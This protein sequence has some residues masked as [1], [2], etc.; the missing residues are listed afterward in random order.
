[1]KNLKKKIFGAFLSA[2]MLT[3]MLPFAVSADASQ[4]PAT[5]NLVWENDFNDE[6]TSTSATGV[7][8]WSTENTDID[9]R[10]E[11]CYYE[12]KENNT[13]DKY[14]YAYPYE[15]GPNK[16]TALG[17]RYSS[18]YFKASDLGEFPLDNIKID[19]SLKLDNLFD[20]SLTSYAP[21]SSNF[22]TVLKFDA[23]GNIVFADKNVDTYT[24][25]SWVDLSLVIDYTTDTVELF[26][27]EEKL[28]S[29]N[30]I[31][32]I[33]EH[34]SFRNLMVRISNA[35]STQPNTYYGVAID[36]L[37][38]YTTH[39]ENYINRRPNIDGCT[40]EFVNLDFKGLTA[41]TSISTTADY[42]VSGTAKVKTENGNEYIAFEDDATLIVSEANTQDCYTYTKFGKYP[43]V[44]KVQFDVKRTAEWTTKVK[45][46]NT[47]IIQL[48]NDNIQFHNGSSYAT[49]ASKIWSEWATISMYMDFANSKYWAY[50]DGVLAGSYTIPTG[51]TTPENLT[52]WKNKLCVDNITIST[53]PPYGDNA[54]VEYTD[55]KYQTK[56]GYVVNNTG[57]D[58]KTY[59]IYCAK[60]SATGVLEGVTVTQ[61]TVAAGAMELEELTT[62][63]ATDGGYYEYF[64]WEQNTLKP[65][66]KKLTVR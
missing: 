58:V 43:D 44:V 20:M 18:G 55:A 46:G 35:S 41:D 53:L 5:W 40:Y 15:V 28:G 6:T 66:V 4:T 42:T 37:K 7:S 34:D 11:Y 8:N 31:Y 1:M 19:I 3:S 30:N 49:G 14:F 33:S 60:F 27:G 21:N 25:G 45:F 9:F 2:V 26:K 51:I 38:Y 32:R 10:L 52:F 50:V 61:G 16:T 48:L 22:A 39:G 23:N 56:I 12:I 29:S 64:V 62:Q 54:I 36:N 13:S 57:S 47:E 65:L 17:N 63:Q 24:A 59:D